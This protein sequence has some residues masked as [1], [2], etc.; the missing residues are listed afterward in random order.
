MI[1][2]TYEKQPSEKKDYDVDYSRWL[3]D[4]EDSLDN[5]TTTVE[6]LDDPTDTSLMVDSLAIT[7]TKLKLWL[8][9]GTSGLEYKVTIKAET[10]GSRLDESE[11]IFQVE[12][13]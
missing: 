6:C 9:G 11:L 1:L 5:I 13:V 2:A 8:V 7:A 4:I 3:L 12:D 10:V